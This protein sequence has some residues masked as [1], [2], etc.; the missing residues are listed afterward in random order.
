MFGN[1]AF[2]KLEVFSATPGFLEVY[3]ESGD[4][5]R[6]EFRKGPSGHCEWRVRRGLGSGP[7]L[8]W[9]WRR[10]SGWSEKHLREIDG[11]R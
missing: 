2:T 8:R 10:G 1:L 6:F 5:L 9:W 7:P 4:M 11:T 3:A